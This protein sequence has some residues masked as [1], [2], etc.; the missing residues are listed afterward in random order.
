MIDSTI[1]LQLHRLT[2]LS[3]TT[4]HDTTATQ[5]TLKYCQSIPRVSALH[6]RLPRRHPRHIDHTKQSP[7]TLHSQSCPV[8]SNAVLPKPAPTATAD[9]N[10]SAAPPG[11]TPPSATTQPRARSTPRH[12]QPTTALAMATRRARSSMASS[13]KE[14]VAVAVSI[15]S[16]F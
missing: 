3:L 5:A 16:N 8:H 4:R 11:I 13:Q 7:H 10:P 15:H 9:E 14:R 6:P 12:F 2:H 1:V